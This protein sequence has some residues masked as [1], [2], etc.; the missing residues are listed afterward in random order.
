M[1]SIDFSQNLQTILKQIINKIISSFKPDDKV[2]YIEPY[3]L[4][5]TS[6]KNKTKSSFKSDDK[7][8]Y[9]ELYPIVETSNNNK[10]MIAKTI[11]Q[12][13]KIHFNVKNENLQNLFAVGQYATGLNP[14]IGLMII[15]VP[16]EDI[17]EAKEL[18]KNL[19]EDD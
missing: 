14:M 7:I 3:P 12:N 10:I 17:D 15:E 13:A 6:N 9:I 1:S 2:V 8:E 4:V 11:L 16:K 19:F 5:E 18:L